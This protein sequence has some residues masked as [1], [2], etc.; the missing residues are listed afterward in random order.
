MVK[1]DIIHT[2]LGGRLIQ[3]VTS[4]TLANNTA[5]N[6]YNA[7]PAGKRRILLSFRV[8]NPDN[9][10][11][12]VTVSKFKE[13]ARTNEIKR[14]VYVAALGASGGI[15]QWPL[16][17]NTQS[18]ARESNRPFELYNENNVLAIQYAAGGASAG[19]TDADGIV[20]EWLEFDM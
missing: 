3:E 17:A 11:R 18:E 6:V 8:M 14:V 7:V 9:V 15:L 5:Y 12:A 10:A 20:I 4:V 13:V 16:G 19:G 1:E 2:M